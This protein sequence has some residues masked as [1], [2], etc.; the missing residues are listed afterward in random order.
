MSCPSGTSLDTSWSC[1]VIRCCDDT[2]CVS[3]VY[4]ACVCATFGDSS[5]SQP[6]WN[7]SFIANCDGSSVTGTPLGTECETLNGVEYAI[8]CY[9]RLRVPGDVGQVG[10]QLYYN[11]IYDTNDQCALFR[12]VTSTT[13]RIH[14][15]ANRQ[16]TR[17]SWALVVALLTAAALIH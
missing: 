9:C 4:G 3:N 13:P 12:A 6:G 10:D 16:G 11:A 14:S 15:A 8:S 5:P 17:S 7:Y 2:S 1:D